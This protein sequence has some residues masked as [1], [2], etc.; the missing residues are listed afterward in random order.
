MNK[1]KLILSGSLSPELIRMFKNIIAGNFS[2]SD[3]GEGWLTD[4]GQTPI[5]P[6]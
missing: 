4:S 6:V 1:N 2:T 5:A 3:N